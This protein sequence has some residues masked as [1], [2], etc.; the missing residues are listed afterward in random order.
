MTPAQWT[1]VDDYLCERL[2]A[3][4]AVLDAALAASEAAGLPPIQVAPNQ[5]KLLH[6][7][8]LSIGA[9]RVLEVGTLGGYS[10]LWLA[11]ALPADGQ[12]ITLELDPHHAA[13]ARENFRRA[14]FDRLIEVR[15]GAARA[16]LDGLV[17]AQANESSAPFD[18]VFIDADKPNN[19]HYYE[20]AV[21]LTRP[22]GLIVVDN[23]VRAGRVA[24]A[25]SRDAAV[26]G[27]RALFDR[28][29]ADARVTAT[30]VQTVGSKGHDGLAVVRVNG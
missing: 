26:L 4:D 29:H 3:P 30:A 10:T 27:T 12:L 6:L 1:Q 21:T 24:D 15:V 2:L 8:A 17:A 20:A 25:D 5:G 16:A 9:R 23:V 14:G 28:L 13:V 19:P 7:L 18:F 22:G 11:R